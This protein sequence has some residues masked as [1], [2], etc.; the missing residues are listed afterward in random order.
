MKRAKHQ[1]SDTLFFVLSRYHQLDAFVF[2]NIN[3]EQL[4]SF[5]RTEIAFINVKY[6]N[7]LLQNVFRY[8]QMPPVFT[9]RMDLQYDIYPINSLHHKITLTS[10]FVPV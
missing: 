9:R 4:V 3:N 8:D 1:I 5:K 7:K 6:K 2:V 10:G